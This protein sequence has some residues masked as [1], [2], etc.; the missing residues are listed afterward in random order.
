MVVFEAGIGVCASVW[1]VVQALVAEE[2][3]TLAY[4]RP[5]FGAATTTRVARSRVS[6]PTLPRSWI[7]L[8]RKVRLSW[9]AQVWVGRLFGCSP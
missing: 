4:D 9:L 8:S 5:G 3:R 7:G 2:T 1:V 6:S